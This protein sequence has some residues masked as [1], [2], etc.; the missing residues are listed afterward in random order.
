MESTHLTSGLV[1]F[2][3]TLGGCTRIA[4]N[5]DY[6]ARLTRTS[7]FAFALPTALRRSRRSCSLG[8]ELF[9][10]L[11]DLSGLMSKRNIAA[12][13]EWSA[14]N[15]EPV[16]FAKG[17]GVL[18]TDCPGCSW[19]LWAVYDDGLLDAFMQVVLGFANMDTLVPGALFSLDSSE[20]MDAARPDS[21]R[22]RPL[23]DWV[24]E[25]LPILGAPIVSLFFKAASESYDV[26]NEKSE[27]DD[28]EWCPS[29]DDGEGCL[30][31][32][33]LSSGS[34]DDENKEEEQEEQQATRSATATQRL[35]PG[36]HQHEEFF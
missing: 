31:G 5:L 30:S 20:F 19:V 21:G 24:R 32:S 26:T 18:E 34:S 11:V 13:E 10:R 28:G 4:R 3:S 22:W 8:N 9:A 29:D 16:D 27:D 14:S 36:S 1:Q 17:A 12:E 7:C 2:G 6:L 25:H 15:V 23:R 33:T 35:T